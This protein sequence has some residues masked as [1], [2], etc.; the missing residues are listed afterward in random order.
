MCGGTSHHS[1][2]IQAVL[3]QIIMGLGSSHLEEQMAAIQVPSIRTP[4]SL[5]TRHMLITLWDE[6]NHGELVI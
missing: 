6:P 4:V 3:E 1:T 5:K 2:N